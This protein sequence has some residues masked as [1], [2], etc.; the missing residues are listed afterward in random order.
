MNTK[1]KMT[2]KS[3]ELSYK[4]KEAIKVGISFALVYIIALKF[5][6]LNP[7]W[8]GLAIALVAVAPAGQ[9]IH[10]GILRIFGTFYG[11][12]I[13]LLIFAVAAQDRWI[14]HFDAMRAIKAVPGLE[15]R[16]R[17]SWIDAD[18]SPNAYQ[19]YNS[20]TDFRFEVDYFF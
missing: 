10:K 18:S 15:F 7:Y 19:D 5:A 2:L 14:I 17:L 8:A 6:W 13:A 3:F 1:K 4:A 12:T 20:Y 9:N 16:A 11:V